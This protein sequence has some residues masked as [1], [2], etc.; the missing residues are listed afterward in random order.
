MRG[1]VSA[2][3]TAVLAGLFRRRGTRNNVVAVAVATPV[4]ALLLGR[5]SGV[6]ELGL[7][8][9]GLTA[10]LGCLVVPL[11]TGGVDDAA[12]WFWARVPRRPVA[13]QT[14]RLSAGVFGQLVVL[15]V[16]VVPLVAVFG[17][18][19]QAVRI[20]V[21]VAAVAGGLALVAGQVVRGAT[22]GPWTSARRTRC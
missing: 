12:G 10:V 2:Q 18:P 3:F 22:T 11:A 6:P 4:A 16:C 15:L 13:V 8:L 7:F 17:M 21:G 5:L 1:P 9:A 19:A 14:V 20:V